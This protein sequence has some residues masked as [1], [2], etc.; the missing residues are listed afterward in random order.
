MEIPA[1]GATVRYFDAEGVEH[2]ATVIA[3]DP[4]VY[5]P[6]AAAEGALS[7]SLDYHGAIMTPDVV[8]YAPVPTPRCWTPL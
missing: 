1:I 6:L 4:A 3:N 8:E 2:P 7:L 5:A